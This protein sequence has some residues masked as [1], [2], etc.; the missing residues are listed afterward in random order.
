MDA[1]R[2][3]SSRARRKSSA[4]RPRPAEDDYV[5]RSFGAAPSRRVTKRGRRNRKRGG[6]SDARS[7]SRSICRGREIRLAIVRGFFEGQTFQLLAFGRCDFPASTC[8]LRTDRGALF[9][10]AS[11]ENNAFIG[12]ERSQLVGLNEPRFAH[13]LLAGRMTPR[14]FRSWMM[15]LQLLEAR[16]RCARKLAPVP[17]DV[18]WL[19]VVVL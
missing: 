5:A 3:V 8:G 18:F 19:K 17:L 7:R 13:M 1:L 15:R 10:A 6:R 11:R 4:A 14:L 12:I 16:R 9:R 2:Q